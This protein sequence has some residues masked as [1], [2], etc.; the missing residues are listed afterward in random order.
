MTAL[1]KYERL[2]CDGLW[3]ADKDAQRRDVVISFGN[4]TLVIADNTGR[5]L[6]HWSLPALERR[7]PGETPAI[8]VPGEDADETVEIADDLMIDAITAIQKALDKS[9][10]KPGKLRF[11][12]TLS[13]VAFALSIAVFWLPG[14][15]SRQTLA[16]VPIAK[17]MEIGASLLAYMQDTTG[18]ACREPR[19]NIALT[20]L[21]KRLFGN[22]TRTR[23]VV[24]PQLEQGALA[25]PGRLILVDYRLLQQADD[26][27]A[28]AGFIVASRAKTGENDPLETLLHR[29]GLGVTF[30]LLT[31]GEIPADVLKDNAQALVTTQ[32]PAPQ[33]AAIYAAFAN[34]QIPIA[35][36]LNLLDAATGNMPSLGPG[37]LDGQALPAIMTDSAWVSLQNICN[38]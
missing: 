33:R 1:A 6:T 26:P 32:A 19:A 28:I 18:T 13:A 27:A 20:D 22:E 12:M 11:F 31:T 15:L 23:I 25:I 4:A 5:P 21:A 34:A 24:V 2:E 35:P 9:R 16:V 37:P 3:R 7:N 29:A 17:R 14:A 38:V 36:Y 8:F 10:P 30:R